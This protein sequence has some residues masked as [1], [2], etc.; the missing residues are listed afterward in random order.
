MHKVLVCRDDGTANEIE[1]IDRVYF[2]CMNIV[3]MSKASHLRRVL[4]PM[5][6]SHS[7]SPAAWIGILRLLSSFTDPVFKSVLL[8][9]SP[10]LQNS[11]PSSLVLL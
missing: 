1:S 2:H 5:H 4:V 11:A 7:L 9:L 8:Y 3:E 10:K 6:Y